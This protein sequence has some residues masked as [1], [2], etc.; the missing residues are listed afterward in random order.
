VRYDYEDTIRSLFIR[1]L[2]IIMRKDVTRGQI[3]D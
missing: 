3:S 2:W 1:S